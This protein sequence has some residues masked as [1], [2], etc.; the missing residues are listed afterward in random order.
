VLGR[1]LQDPIGGLTTLL[2][3]RCHV[4]GGAEGDDQ[5]L[6]DSNVLDAQKLIL[7]EVEKRSEGAA[8]AYGR[9][10][11]GQID[12]ARESF[13]NLSASG[14]EAA[15]ADI[16]NAAQAA[17]KFFQ[18]PSTQRELKQAFRRSRPTAGTRRTRS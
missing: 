15:G 10:L 16:S 13:K 2:P 6:V 11:P 12:K 7:A 8:E 3:G 14:D 1:A 5:E 17:A 4:H 18:K 9:T